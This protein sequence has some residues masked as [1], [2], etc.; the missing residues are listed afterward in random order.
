MV[1]IIGAVIGV[2]L[3][4]LLLA[5]ILWRLKKRPRVTKDNYDTQVL[6]MGGF[7]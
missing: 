6:W 4:V 3:L 5:I 7:V 2:L 1:A